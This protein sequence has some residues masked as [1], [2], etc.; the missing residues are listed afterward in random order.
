MMDVTDYDTNA[1]KI[2]DLCLV[3]LIKITPFDPDF[4]FFF[5]PKC[6]IIKIMSGNG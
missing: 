4:W 2:I 5:R 3:R 6:K 1:L